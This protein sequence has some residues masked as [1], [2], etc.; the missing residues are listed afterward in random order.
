MDSKAFRAY[1][2]RH[3]N[4]IGEEHVT[5]QFISECLS[6]L[7]IEHCAMA[8]DCVL[9]RVEGRRGNLK[10][11]VVVC[12]EIGALPVEEL[13][14]VDFASQ[15]RGVMHAAGNDFHAAVVYGVLKRLAAERDFE[16]TLLA[17]FYTSESGCSGG[18]KEILAQNPFGKYDVAAVIGEQVDPELEVGQVGFCPGRFMASKDLL[19][20]TI[21]GAGCC[22]AM[23]GDSVG[24]G[25]KDPI[26]AM[27]DM[28]LRLSSLGS[29]LC[30]VSI[31][32]VE[33][34]GTAERIP[35]RV[36]LQGVLRAHDEK[37]RV[38]VKDMILHITEEVEY[39][40]DVEIETEI[41]EGYP[42]V[43]NDT[44]L[45]YEA[46]LLADSLGLKVVDL[47]RTPCCDDFGHYSHIY[48]SLYY[49]LGVGRRS[50]VR[51]TATFL[52]DEKAMTVGENFMY[53][54]TLSILNK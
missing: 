33:A 27:A 41:N 5:A 38:R 32:K 12:A 6:E 4:P 10:R 13:T 14:G 17:L 43:E 53:E 11:C 37:L 15:N 36:R 52:P 48:P 19:S 3:P 54:L 35:D 24:S 9:A 49:R 30:L 46:M 2:H 50:G 39:K 18:V 51:Q 1:L 23:G 20:F 16:G 40:H 21:R 47:D 22:G 45:S 28:I 31:G 8:S 42:S 29:D 25:A 34:D 44:H 7:A 26:V